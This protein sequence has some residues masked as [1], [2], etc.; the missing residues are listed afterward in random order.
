MEKTLKH[1]TNKTLFETI[2]QVLLKKIKLTRNNAQRNKQKRLYN[3]K[4]DIKK[5][6]S[7]Y[8]SNFLLLTIPT[9][10]LNLTKQQVIKG[11]FQKPSQ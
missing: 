9:I 5:N 3:F 6:Q 10:Q 11:L 2:N 8:A 7:K 4:F 1:Q